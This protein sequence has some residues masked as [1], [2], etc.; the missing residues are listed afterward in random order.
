[1]FSI[2]KNSLLLLILL[3]VI[4]YA[5]QTEQQ[6]DRKPAFISDSLPVYLHSGP[7][8]QYRII[9]SV[10]AGQSV[11]YLGED[12]ET[13][14][15]QIQDEARTGWLPK[16]YIKYTPGMSAQL[17]ALQASQDEQNALVSSLQHE[18]DQLA[19]QL[20]DALTEQQQTQQQLQQANQAYEQIKS[21]LNSVQ[22]SIWQD[23]MIIGSAILVLGL[24]LGLCL[25]LL[26]PKRRNDRWM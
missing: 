13:G 3:P 26:W 25:P 2:F 6:G 7:S 22:A 17:E 5:Q 24:L 9:G 1:M 12:R 21:Q 10:N 11:I 8:N 4:S 18:R 19:Q 20:N 23:P 15:A 14:Y 16:Q